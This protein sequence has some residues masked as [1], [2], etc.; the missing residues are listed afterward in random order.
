ML[1]DRCVGPLGLLLAVGLAASLAG[2]QERSSA[3]EARPDLP[4]ALA[5]PPAVAEAPSAAVPPQDMCLVPASDFLM[6]SNRGD[7]DERPAHRVYL[8]AF[9]IDRTEV[10]NEQYGRFL[11][12]I[13]RSGDHRSYCFPGEPAG[14]DH[15][16][17][18][19]DQVRWNG[20]K[21]PVVGVDWFDASA[22]ARWAGKRLPT[23]TEWEKAARGTD[24]REYPWGNPWDPDRCCWDGNFDG[25]SR[26]VGSF[27][28]GA[29]PCGALDMA[30]NVWEWCADWYGGEYYASS[31]RRNPRGPVRGQ[32]RVL[33]GGSWV[34]DPP[35]CRT[36][37]RGGIA[38]VDRRI[39]IGI[40]C[41][42]RP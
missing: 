28:T 35:I 12:W 33:R 36:V 32:M 18:N 5:A 21:Q 34:N 39:Y 4:Q 29:S 20:L 37:S 25:S 11:D 41:A 6:G 31:P 15:T 19:W 8:D 14:K 16:P 10:T 27:P 38:P 22:Y 7:P 3:G 30:G 17:A 24:G 1:G 23:E 42:S 2:A 40:R 13:R 9:R 26:E